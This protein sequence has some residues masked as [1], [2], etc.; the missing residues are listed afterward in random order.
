MVVVN[1]C[2]FGPENIE[3]QPKHVKGRQGRS[4]RWQEEQEDVLGTILAEDEVERTGQDRIYGYF[5]GRIQ[6]VRQADC[7]R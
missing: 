6:A 7:A 4:D 5:A 2:F 1:P 3:V